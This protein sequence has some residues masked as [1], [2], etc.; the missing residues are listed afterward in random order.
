VARIKMNPKRLKILAVSIAILIIALSLTVA[1]SQSPIKEGS[2][3][4]LA[5]VAC[6]GDSITNMTDYPA[7]LQALLGQNSSVRNFGMDGATV[8]FDSNRTYYFSDE[9]FAARGFLP[10]TVIIML[11]TNDAR[12]TIYSQIDHFVSDYE[13]MIGKVENFSSKPQIFL[14]EPP[15]IY[16]NTMN[17]N[18]TN[19][20][21]GVIPRIQQVADKLHLPIIDIYTPLLNHPDYFT[22]GVHPNSRGAQVIANTIYDA[23]TTS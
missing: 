2:D 9:Y 14:V 8:N 15:P 4:K 10:T 21:Q 16:S 5:L 23:I 20:V 6:L 19:L 7:D 3:D 22:D 12:T 13:H 17:L 1:F 11:G 18:G